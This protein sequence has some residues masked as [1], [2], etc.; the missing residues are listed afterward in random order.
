MA[1][2]ASPGTRVAGRYS[3]TLNER[4]QLQL[5]EEFWLPTSRVAQRRYGKSRRLNPEQHARALWQLVAG[6]TWQNVYARETYSNRLNP[7]LT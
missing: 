3:M 6:P 2:E 4:Q 1:G 5:E 7:S